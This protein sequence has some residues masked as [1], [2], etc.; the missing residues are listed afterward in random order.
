MAI[1]PLGAK[2]LWMRCFNLDKGELCGA[3]YP[4]ACEMKRGWNSTDSEL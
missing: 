1:L 2:L 3:Y 4:S